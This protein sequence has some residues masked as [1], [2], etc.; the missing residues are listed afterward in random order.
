[1]HCSHLMPGVHPPPVAVGG[2]TAI[3]AMLEAS[4]S[5]TRPWS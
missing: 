5:E 2:P 4:V 1:M 3:S